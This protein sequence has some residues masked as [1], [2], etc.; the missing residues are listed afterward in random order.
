[1]ETYQT[2]NVPPN[3]EVEQVA[4]Q[5]NV[6]MDEARRN[7]PPPPQNQF[8]PQQDVFPPE[9]ARTPTL[10]HGD[11]DKY[12]DLLV[13]PITLDPVREV[14]RLDGMREELHM[15]AKKNEKSSQETVELQKNPASFQ[16]SGE[17]LN[18]TRKMHIHGARFFYFMWRISVRH[19]SHATK[20]YLHGGYLHAPRN[21]QTSGAHQAGMR[22]R[23]FSVAHSMVHHIIFLLN[24]KKKWRPIWPS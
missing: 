10:L 1:L 23:K 24:F 6:I 16:V 9:T 5:E 19:R 7:N 11:P 14:T 22:H 12:R 20:F 8:P 3:Q 2:T 17:L 4:S 15:E 18:T 21:Y 13:T